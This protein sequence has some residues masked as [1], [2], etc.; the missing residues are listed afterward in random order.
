VGNE[1]E[2]V[3]TQATPAAPPPA[4][5]RRGWRRRWLRRLLAVAVLA[6]GLYLFR[7][8]LLRALAGFLV[9]DEGTAPATYVLPLDGLTP[10]RQAIRLA[11]ADPKA[12]VLLLEPPPRRLVAYGILPPDEAWI[13]EALSAAGRG[14][15]VRVIHCAGHGD[16][17]RVR[18]LARLLEDEPRAEVVAL[19]QRFHGRRWRRLRD[20]LLPPAAAA[21]VRLVSVRDPAYDEA[22]WWRHKLGVLAF[23]DAYLGYAYVSLHGEDEGWRTWDPD[24]YE[25]SL[26]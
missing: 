10:H 24:D 15:G 5:P 7:A 14:D 9:V 17:D 4:A 12:R 13:Q 22:D 21:R 18:E 19:C 26:R 6:L 3:E 23:F 11:E 2:G 1:P 20:A 8:P 16:W 25:K